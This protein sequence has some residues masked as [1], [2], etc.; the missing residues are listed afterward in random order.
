MS[1]SFLIPITREPQGDFAPIPSSKAI[2]MKHPTQKFAAVRK[3]EVFIVASE[4]W[5]IFFRFATC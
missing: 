2:S 1:L 3:E 5:V 4:A